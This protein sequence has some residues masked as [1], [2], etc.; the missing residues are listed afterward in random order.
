M[1]HTVVTAYNQTGSSATSSC[2][3]IPMFQY[4]IQVCKIN[5]VKY[6]INRL[7]KKKPTNILQMKSAP[8]TQTQLQQH[9]SLLKITSLTL[10]NVTDDAV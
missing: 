5:L 7:F 1:P 2:S 8:W 6:E 3:P 9:K 4:F 10:H